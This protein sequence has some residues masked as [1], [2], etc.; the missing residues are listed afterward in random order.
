LKFLKKFP[1]LT[2]M[3]MRFERETV[4]AMEQAKEKA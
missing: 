2:G 4:A 3:E 1:I